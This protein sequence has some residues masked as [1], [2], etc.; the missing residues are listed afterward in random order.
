MDSRI[1]FRSNIEFADK[2]LLPLFELRGSCLLVGTPP[3]NLSLDFETDPVF[4]VRLRTVDSGEPS[5]LE[6]ETVKQIRLLDVDEAPRG[7]WLNGSS[8]SGVRR[9]DL[10][11]RAFEKQRWD[12]VSS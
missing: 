9:R 2:Q 3:G 1:F 8:V 12:S 7:V 5:A 11:R 10:G 6:L 4:S